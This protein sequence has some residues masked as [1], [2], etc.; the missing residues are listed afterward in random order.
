MDDQQ[1]YIQT[2]RPYGLLE[3]K[4]GRR[5]KGGRRG[6]KEKEKRRRRGEEMRRGEV[7]EDIIFIIYDNNEANLVSFS[8]FRSRPKYIP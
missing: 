5:E 8:L 6:E 1:I 3:R 7:Q 4:E 2:P